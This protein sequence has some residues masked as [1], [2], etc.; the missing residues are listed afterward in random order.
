MQCKIFDL[1]LIE[2]GRAL[3]FQ[4]GI[5]RRVKNN[6][7]SGA[8][9]ICRHYP[10][11]TFGRA[12]KEE[13]ILA[14]ETQLKRKDIQLYNI[15]RGGDVTYHGPGQLI[16]YPIVN[17]SHFRKDIH[18]F[19]R[20]LEGIAIAALTRFGISGVRVKDKTG[21]WVGD[22]KIASIGVAIRQWITFHG[23]AI[24][25]KR[26]DLHNF[27]LIKPCGMDIMMTSMET[28]LDKEVAIEKVKEAII[29]E[30]F[31]KGD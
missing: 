3:D 29:Q 19:L 30:N 1:G 6:E 26:D 16:V 21:V 12:F 11:I 4:K 17:L 2:F 14:D 7:F 20:E 22:K 24:N 28:V 9:V 18:W 13:N 5:F 31:F 23:L 10:I 25:V 15:K 27:T 8:L